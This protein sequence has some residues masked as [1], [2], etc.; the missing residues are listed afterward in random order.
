MAK[1]QV[2]TITAEGQDEQGNTVTE[3]VVTTVF[4][5]DGTQDASNLLAVAADMIAEQASAHTDALAGSV[6]D[7][8]AVVARLDSATERLALALDTFHGGRG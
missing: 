2:V 4:M 1:T 7:L 8:A 3:S 5:L 6:A